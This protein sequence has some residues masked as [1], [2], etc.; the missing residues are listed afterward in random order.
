ME[1]YENPDMVKKAFDESFL[2]ESLRQA[3][4]AEMIE[5]KKIIKE[6]SDRKEGPISVLDIGIGNARVPKHLCGIKEIWNK[7]DRYLGIDHSDKCIEL[8]KEVIKE[9]SLKDKLEVLKLDGVNL[10]TLKEKFDLIICTWFTAGNF[11]PE[12]FSFET[13]SSG[14]LKEKVNLDKNEKFT[15]IFSNAYKLLNSKGEIVLGSVYID[16]EATNEKQEDFYKKCGMEIIS[17]P[18]DSVTVTKNKYWSQRFTKEKIFNYL[19]FVPKE[20]ISFTPL[21]IYEYAM[22]IRIKK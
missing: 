9:Y 12:D 14:K 2:S 5:L 15:K 6:L 10:G 19:D 18:K 3:Q 8:T 4:L 22:L 20:K 21:D 1:M 17:R 16:N 13:D 11:Y 7:I